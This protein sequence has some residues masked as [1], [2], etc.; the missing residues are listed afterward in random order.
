METPTLGRLIEGDARRD[1]VHVAI[2]PVTAGETVH[3]GQHVGFLAD[4]TVGDV[5]PRDRIGVIDPFLKNVV[6]SGWRCWLCLY[7]NTV[8]SL[9]HV[10][11]HPAF[12]TT[13]TKEQGNV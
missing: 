5:D 6:L 12:K 13:P 8:T 7:P 9:R 4:G 1:A 3:P 11:Q 10:W 2:A